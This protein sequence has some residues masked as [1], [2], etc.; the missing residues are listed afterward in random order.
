M[1]YI[2]L[3]C[4]GATQDFRSAATNNK[5]VGVAQKAY[6]RRRCWEWHEDQLAQRKRNYER[7]DSRQLAGGHK[8]AHAHKCWEWHEGRL[9][10]DREQQARTA[11]KPRTHC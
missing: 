7:A 10:A 2:C 6:P 3:K 9:A 4:L 5:A 8:A 1:R 11:R